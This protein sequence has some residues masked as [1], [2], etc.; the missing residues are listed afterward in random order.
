MY[1]LIAFQYWLL[2]HCSFCWCPPASFPLVHGVKLDHITFIHG[3]QE[4]I[5]ACIEETILWLHWELQWWQQA[6]TL[7]SK[8]KSKRLI[9]PFFA[10]A[11]KLWPLTGREWEEVGATFKSLFCA[12]VLQ[13]PSLSGCI[14]R[15]NWERKRSDGP[16]IN[17][18][19]HTVL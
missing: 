12:L 1:V 19:E 4:A 15:P 18:P 14:G 11:A 16:W 10:N 8:L 2:K 13:L 17:M 3:L 5:C 9:K 7:P 6:Q